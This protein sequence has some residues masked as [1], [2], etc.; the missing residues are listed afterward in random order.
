MKLI[1][2]LSIVWTI[3]IGSII[4][5]DLNNYNSI[6]INKS[7]CCKADIRIYHNKPMCVNCKL[8]CDVKAEHKTKRKR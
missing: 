5:W 7:D 6:Y 3:V 4:Y 2:A 1:I 8:F